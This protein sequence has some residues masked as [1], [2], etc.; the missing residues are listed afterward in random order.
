MINPRDQD[1]SLI[2]S[3][4]Q[5]LQQQDW[6]EAR[7]LLNTDEVVEVVVTGY[8]RGGVLVR[9]RRLEGFIPTS[10]LLSVGVAGGDRRESLNASSREL[11][12]K[13]IEVDQSRR[14]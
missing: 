10:H 2:V 13:V 8:N 3:I 9:W 1:G 11:G 7:R 5:G 12:V 14:R 4:S 6:E